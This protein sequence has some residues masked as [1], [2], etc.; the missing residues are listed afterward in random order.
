MHTEQN[1]VSLILASA[2]PR[3]KELLAQLGVQYTVAPA[4]IDESVLAGEDPWAYV[5]RMAEE[6]ARAGF[7][8]ASPGHE[9]VVIGADT[10]VVLNDTILGKPTDQ[11][12]AIAMLEMLSGQTHHVLSCVALTDGQRIASR[13]S[14]T[15][16]KFRA[17]LPG[18]STAYWQSGEPIDKAGAYA[19]QGLGALFVKGIQG[20]YTGVVGLP[21]YET[22]E[23]L[24]LF[25]IE[26]GLEPA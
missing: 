14:D 9:C 22:A 1:S 19:I 13:L 5:N 7:A 6:K 21:L 17:L 15:E 25:G 20:S 2:S 11:Q 16:V 10:T 24:T 12:D 8:A 4:D 23:L 26:L 18:E 3:R